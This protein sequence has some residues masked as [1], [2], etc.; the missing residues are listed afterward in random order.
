MSLEDGT[1]G[2]EKKFKPMNPPTGEKTG[3]TTENGFIRSKKAKK[4]K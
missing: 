2:K 4:S 3:R 1:S